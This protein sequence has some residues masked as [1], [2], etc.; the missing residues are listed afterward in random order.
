MVKF[1]FNYYLLTWKRVR[2]GKFQGWVYALKYTLGRYF[3]V[4]IST[5]PTRGH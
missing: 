1:Y 4:P 3:E 5:S 2:L